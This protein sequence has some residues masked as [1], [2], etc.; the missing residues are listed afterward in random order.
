MNKPKLGEIS[1]SMH[2]TLNHISVLNLSTKVG[3]CED[4][5]TG[6][7]LVEVAIKL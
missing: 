7:C 5:I 2:K 6:S 3:V 4:K 1:E